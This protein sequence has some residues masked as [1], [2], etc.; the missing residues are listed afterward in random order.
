MTLIEQQRDRQMRQV[1]GCH[2]RQRAKNAQLVL[3]VIEAAQLN[4]RI[5]KRRHIMWLSC[6]DNVMGLVTEAEKNKSRGVYN[7]P[8]NFKVIILIHRVVAIDDQCLE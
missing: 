8:E 4:R 7:Q 5:D 6:I 3:R 2:I 1:Q